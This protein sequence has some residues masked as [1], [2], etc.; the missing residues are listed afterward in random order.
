M[1]AHPPHARTSWPG[2]IRLALIALMLVFGGLGGVARAAGPAVSLGVDFAPGSPAHP[3]LGQAFAYSLSPQNV[4]DAALD[5]P[6]MIDTLP[7]QLQVTSVTTG[8]YSNASDVGAGEGVRVSYEK[9][10][11]RAAPSRQSP[12]GFGSRRWRWFTTTCTGQLYPASPL[13]EKQERA[14]KP[15]A[16]CHES[17]AATGLEL[18][19]AGVSARE[20]Q[21]S[22]RKCAPTASSDL[23]P[24]RA[25]R[26]R[27]SVP[28]T[29]AHQHRRRAFASE[30]PLLEPDALV[31]QPPG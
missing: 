6:T 30:V 4:G 25:M 5:G 8:T 29:T 22:T 23:L 12:A 24:V 21:P 10:T 18:V 1:R 20:P 2:G 28:A 26:S 7:I 27:S 15:I 3:D 17:A 14:A 11:A 16:Y 31:R 13:I 9:N 19:P